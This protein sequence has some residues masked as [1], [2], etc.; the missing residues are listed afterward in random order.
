MRDDIK[1]LKLCGGKFVPEVSLEI[2]SGITSAN[3]KASCSVIYGRNG[4]GKSTIARAFRSIAG[5]AETGIVSAALC[6]GEGNEIK[7]SDDEVKNIY[8]FDQKF[9]DEKI[10]IDGDGLDTIV[11]IGEQVELEKQIKTV[12]ESL[13][14]YNNEVESL[15]KQISI[16]EDSKKP[17]SPKYF[18]DKMLDAL[19]GDDKWSGRDRKIRGA[20]ARNNTH[21]TSDMF[22]SFIK[23][24]PTRT[25]D[26]L[27][28]EFNIKLNLLDKIRAE[29]QRILVRVPN[30]QDTT[31]IKQIVSLL[32]ERIEEPHLNFRDKLLL[33]VLTK[34]DARFLE[35]ISNTFSNKDNKYCPFCTKSIS[36]EEKAELVEGIE[37][38]LGDLVKKHQEKLDAI[39]PTIISL[40][41]VPFE[42]LKKEYEKCRECLE[43]YNRTLS[44]LNEK[45]TEKINNPYTPI[46]VS[47]VSCMLARRKLL[48]SLQELESARLRYNEGV[49][50][51]DSLKIE[52]SDINSMIAYYDIIVFYKQYQRLLVQRSLLE[53]YLKSAELNRNKEQEELNL[54]LAKKKN[55][56]IAL[57]VINESL[58]YIFFSKDRL[59]IIYSEGTYK[60]LVNGRPVKP[61][62]ISTG[63]INVIAL[64]YF[65][66]IIGKEK[67]LQDVYCDRY[68][69]VIDDPISSFDTENKVGMLSYLKSEMQQF[70]I[71]NKESKFLIMTH[72]L[73]T[74]SHL[75]KI[76]RELKEKVSWASLGAK[77]Y[78]LLANYYHLEN[79]ELKLTRVEHEEYSNL[80]KT[81]YNYAKSNVDN[82]NIGI[83]NIM[84]QLLEAFSTF[85]FKVSMEELTTKKCILDKLEKPYREHFENLMYRLVLNGES[86]RKYQIQYEPTS[87][88]QPMY[89]F[90][91]KQRIAKEILCFLYLISREHVIAHLGDSKNE[92]V[93]MAIE[94]DLKAWCE[95]IKL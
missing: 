67:A 1:K 47:R 63:E 45:I 92:A 30:V 22:R 58:S 10:K 29:E 16:L 66:S 75:E 28:R 2:F 14:K 41:L 84:R 76:V 87:V 23:L 60:L 94:L 53:G 6:D 36:E 57:D 49:S 3:K 4:S 40:N 13:S 93:N 90:E 65:F 5:E 26:N 64:C 48:S 15:S 24:K 61:S 8:V 33:E 27:L 46:E 9:I 38:V 43:V 7:I 72:D 17:Q 21:V 44:T 34:R 80:F 59:K 18:F 78:G 25:R 91:E 11:M 89:S 37:K 73:M 68:F 81:T 55:V 31:D 85:Q 79:K 35:D 69:I 56:T 20:A 74:F 86:H 19:R 51:I 54:L 52:L 88:F 32:N 12:Q 77:K 42:K 70:L 71:G 95:E 62:Q 83:G 82:I 39:R 50:D